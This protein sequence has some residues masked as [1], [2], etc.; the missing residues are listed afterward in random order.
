MSTLRFSPFLL[1]SPSAY[2]YFLLNSIS[3]YAV[4][5]GFAFLFFGGK[6]TVWLIII[7]IAA[8]TVVAV[9]I[10]QA[11]R[12]DVKHSQ[13]VPTDHSNILTKSFIYFAHDVEFLTR[14]SGDARA[15]Q[16]NNNYYCILRPNQIFDITEGGEREKQQSKF[17]VAH[18]LAHIASGD[19]RDLHRATL[20]ATLAIFTGI[21][22]F[23]AMLLGHLKFTAKPVIGLLYLGLIYFFLIHWVLRIREFYADKIAGSIIGPEHG[24]GVLSR[25]ARISKFLKF[26]WK[27]F[28]T[29]PSPSARERIF[30]DFR[31]IYQYSWARVLLSA[32]VLS[33][34]F[35]VG[36]LAA[37]GVD[38]NINVTNI[39]L[40][41]A[42]GM[43]F[44]VGLVI[45]GIWLQYYVIYQNVVPVAL[46]NELSMLKVTLRC[47]LLY[48]FGL[49][50]AEIICGLFAD[51]EFIQFASVS[52]S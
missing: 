25:S 26:S 9:I 7:P 38:S 23:I 17:V 51:R 43:I 1:P 45:F 4:I 5:A 30:E 14:P 20:S 37:I 18:E 34:I 35:F 19:T 12:S 46:L 48:I 44:F 41:S 31:E 16:I 40:G 50:N 36:P 15:L 10:Q 24:L 13:K 3:Y 27:Y 42:A 8:V 49:L 22:V 28:L 32:F 29:H 39:G 2:A 11:N 21:A 47:I 6:S 52:E 33:A